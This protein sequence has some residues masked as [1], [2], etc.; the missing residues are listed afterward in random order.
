MEIKGYKLSRPVGFMFIL[1]LAYGALTA[2]Q[3]LTFQNPYAWVIGLTWAVLIFTVGMVGYEFWKKRNL[4]AFILFHLA[5]AF[6]ITN[7]LIFDLYYGREILGNVVL[8]GQKLTLSDR[9]E[10]LAFLLVA[11][12]FLYLGYRC[13]SKN[14][15]LEQFGKEIKQA[16]KNLLVYGAALFSV[17]LPIYFYK[18]H[19][20]YIAVKA[21][22][23]L[24]IHLG[25]ETAIDYP[26]WTIGA[27]FLLETAFCF[28]L[29]ARPSK[30]IFIPIALLF[31]IAKF[32]DSLRGQRILFG[33]A[34]GTVIWYYLNTYIKTL[35]LKHYLVVG[36]VGVV[37]MTSFSVIRSH[38]YQ[39][40]GGFAVVQAQ[41]QKALKGM[42][43]FIEGQSVSIYVFGHMIHYKE[44]FINERHPYVFDKV[45]N[46][47]TPWTGQNEKTIREHNAFS[48]QMSYFLNKQGY[49]RGGGVGGSFL[50]EL[51]DLGKFGFL[52][53]A[54][55]IGTSIFLF[56]Y[57][58]KTNRWV[59][60]ISYYFIAQLLWMPRG[61]VFYSI[62]NILV[63]SAIY[64]LFVLYQKIVQNTFLNFDRGPVTFK[65]LGSGY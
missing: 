51:Y 12:I 45:V 64:V 26:F 34:A 5:I 1:L 46:L 41:V 35:K 16:D 4:T 57:F 37:I 23:Y 24:S 61:E 44:Q 63:T 28:I 25:G 15:K 17:S 62:K 8:W 49:L 32:Y 27:G 65:M 6:F 38:S 19:L 31:T 29:A 56:E 7:R 54:F 30:K 60:L 48:D 33:I 58:F 11:E 55:V 20:K 21:H 47:F 9:I 42:G 22:G 53:G 59:R 18:A 2:S 39:R 13:F 52:L 40:N 50:A 3:Q 10:L 14:K 36:V 43:G